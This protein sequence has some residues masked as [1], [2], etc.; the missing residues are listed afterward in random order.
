MESLKIIPVSSLLQLLCVFLVVFTSSHSAQ[1][2]SSGLEED[3]NQRSYFFYQQSE[4]PQDCSDVMSNCVQSSN[5]SGVFLIKPD[6]YPEP[7]EV[8]CEKDING[9]EWMVIQ[10]RVDGSVKFNRD[11]QEYKNGFGFLS[12]EFWLGNEKLSYLT[13]QG[14]YELNIDV[15][16]FNGTSLSASYAA[17]RISDEWSQYSLVSVGEVY[18]NIELSCPPSM[19]YGNCTCQPS[20]DDPSGLNRCNHSC[21]EAES[22]ICSSGFLL[23]DGECVPLNECECFITQTNSVLSTGQTHVNADCSEK[24]T[25]ENGEISCNFNY[26]CDTNAAC[27]IQDSVRGCYCNEGYEGDGETCTALFTDCYDVRTR[28]N[29]GQ[30]GVYTIMPTGWT[31]SPFNVYCDMTTDGGGWTVFQR[32]TDGVTDFYRTW[33]EYQRGF[34]SVDP[35]NDFWL[36]NEKIYYLTNQKVNKLRVDIVTSGGSAKYSE[37][38]SFEIGDVSTKYQLSIGSQSGNAGNGLRGN[39]GGQF[40]TRDEDNDGCNHHDFAEGHKGGWWYTT[41]IDPSW[42]AQCRFS[43]RYCDRFETRSSCHNIAT[44]SNLNGDYNEGNGK[45]IF[46]TCGTNGNLNSAEMKIRPASA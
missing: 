13:N 36:G 23:K 27:R 7:F 17:F 4:Y 38:S 33:I 46:W 43:T 34:G 35:G 22:C 19:V 14:K 3:S 44:Q 20:C 28:L 29:P 25:C 1:Q 42:C 18:G 5:S 11:W 41:V 8:Y 26:R 31:G 45:N 40:S 9:G 39:N 2:G 32:R 16:L 12:T 37:Y 15:E 30:D 24:C 10:R 21:N 6:G